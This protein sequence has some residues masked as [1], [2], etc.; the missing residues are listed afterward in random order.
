MKLRHVHQWTFDKLIRAISIICLGVVLV[1]VLVLKDSLRTY[2]KSLSLG[3][4]SRDE[5]LRR[6]VRAK[7][8]CAELSTLNCP[9][10][11]VRAELTCA[12]LSAPNCPHRIVLRR[13]VRTPSTCSTSERVVRLPGRSRSVTSL[14]MLDLRD[15]FN[16]FNVADFR[17]N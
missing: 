4:R 8:S 3:V 1:L 12:K 2:F 5:L 13:I 17:C 10:Q 9:R 11:I 6:I 16:A 14:G 15:A 7:L